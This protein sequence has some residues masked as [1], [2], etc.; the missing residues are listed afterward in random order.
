MR[1]IW[2]LLSNVALN[3]R[4][5]DLGGEAGGPDRSSLQAAGEGRSEQR[6]GPAPEPVDERRARPLAASRQLAAGQQLARPSTGRHADRPGPTAG[7][8]ES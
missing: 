2:F 3:K 5:F 4:T 1:V 8:V 6:V 7:L